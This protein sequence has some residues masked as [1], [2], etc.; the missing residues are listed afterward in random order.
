MDNLEESEKNWILSILRGEESGAPSGCVRS[1]PDTIMEFLDNEGIAPLFHHQLVE[2]RREHEIPKGLFDSLRM[3]NLQY[4]AG[5]LVRQKEIGNVINLFNEHNLDYLLLKGEALSVTYYPSPHLRTRTDSDFLFKDKE[6][7]EKAWQLL[8]NT[9][10][11]RGSTLHGDF[12][13]YQFSCRRQLM[14]DVK[15]TL[16]IHHKIANSLCLEKKLLYPELKTASKLKNYQGEPVRV[17]SPLH[18]LI[19]ACLHRVTHK[20]HDTENRLIWIYDIYLL[21]QNLIEDDWQ[22]LVKIAEEKQIAEILVEGLNQA[23]ELFKTSIPES[24]VE[25]LKRAE[26][27]EVGGTGG[28]SRLANYMLNLKNIDNW[29]E[30]LGYIRDMLLP[31]ADYVMAEYHLKSGKLLPWYYLRRIIEVL[32]KR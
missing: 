21:C 23:A 4:A 29:G 28:R 27:K 3:C 18:M 5:N 31:P 15:I 17:L 8:S 1:D 26:N 6:E 13:G 22:Q 24:T 30:R 14:L 32:V 16:D 20:P 11:R 2:T 9:G 12:V 19:H 7:A 25:A 10:Y